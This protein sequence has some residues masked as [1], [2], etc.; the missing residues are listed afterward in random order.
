MAQIWAATTVMLDFFSEKYYG[1][2]K[3]IIYTV[4]IYNVGNMYVAQVCIQRT[5]LYVAQ[6][7]VK[8]SPLGRQQIYIYIYWRH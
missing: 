8:N 2:D 1:R 4:G 6:M 5:T 7:L 3:Y